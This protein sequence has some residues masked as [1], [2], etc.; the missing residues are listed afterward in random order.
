MDRIE[1]LE[2]G[3][4]QVYLNDAGESDDATHLNVTNNATIVV[5]VEPTP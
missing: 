4:V 2:N 1:T 5:N 3:S